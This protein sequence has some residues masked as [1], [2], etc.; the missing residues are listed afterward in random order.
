MLIAR[1]DGEATATICHP[2]LRGRR[3]ALCQPVDPAGADDGP[4]LLAVDI[5]NAARG[6]RVLLTTDGKGIRDRVGDPHS[7][8][9][10]YVLGIVDDAQVT[11]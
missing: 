8:I 1:V 3:L 9:R 6:Q 10:Y 2:S 4:V 5:C 11:A 7:P